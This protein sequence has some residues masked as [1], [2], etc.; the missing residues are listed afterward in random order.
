MSHYSVLYIC[1]AVSQPRDTELFVKR[2][3]K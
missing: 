2:P 3:T 1:D